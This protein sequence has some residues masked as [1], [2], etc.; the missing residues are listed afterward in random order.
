MKQTLAFILILALFIG[1]ITAA[2]YKTTTAVRENPYADR[3]LLERGSELPPLWLYYD[4]DDVN[5]RHWADFGARSSNALNT[6]FL[7]L[8]YGSIV[9]CNGIAYRVEIIGGIGGIEERLGAAALPPGIHEP[10]RIGDAEY[11]W[12]RAAILEKFGGL[13]LDPSTICIKGFGELPKDRI[14]FFGTDKDQTYAGPRGTAVPSLNAIWVPE[15]GHPVMKAWADAAYR[16]LVEK[17][18]GAM[19]RQDAKWDYV[20]YAAENPAVVVIPSAELSRNKRTGKRLQLEDLLATGQEGNLPFDVPGE[21][22]YIPVPWKELRD[23]RAFGWFLRMSEG[24]IMD[25][26]II[27]RDLLMLSGRI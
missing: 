9:A 15:P 14:V 18:T 26:D 11:N 16:R 21:A 12:F 25:S 19:A 22:V 27:I 6:P 8:C 20:A 4:T 13:W 5:S 24:Q 3:F 2:S 17:N 1:G 23:R 10:K 7:N